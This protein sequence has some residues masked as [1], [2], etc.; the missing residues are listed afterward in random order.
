MGETHGSQEE[1]V[2]VA[3]P[4]GAYPEV[5]NLVSR[6]LAGDEPT[7]TTPDQGDAAGE[8]EAADSLEVDVPRSGTWTRADIK[9]LHRTFRNERG[10][11]VLSLIA[12]RSLEGEEAYYGELMDHADLDTYQLRAQLSWLTKKS[13]AVKHAS[14]VWPI[15]VRDNGSQASAGDRLSYHMPP[16]VAQWWLDEEGHDAPGSSTGTRCSTTASSVEIDEAS[17]LYLEGWTLAQ[18]GQRYGVSRERIRQVLPEDVKER[19][20]K[21]RAERQHEDIR[22]RLAQGWFSEEIAKASGLEEDTVRQLAYT[23]CREASEAGEPRRRERRTEENGPCRICGGAVADR[24]TAITC[25]PWC[26]EAYLHLRYRVDE[27]SRQSHRQ[28]TAR[29]HLAHG[30]QSDMVAETAKTGEPHYER[31]RW[32]YRDSESLAWAAECVRRGYSPV[33]EAMGDHEMAQIQQYL[34]QQGPAT[35][36]AQ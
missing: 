31:T 29:W 8:A 9:E 26:Y 7:V 17:R 30:G 20:K 15:V 3:V 36:Q 35:E 28:A 13:Q 10:R 12:Q 5:L 18:I 14:F 27:Q 21:R 6:Y 16:E 11:A 25:S 1:L 22:Q 34:D 19:G 32:F 33:I 23:H 4:R 24:A 2:N